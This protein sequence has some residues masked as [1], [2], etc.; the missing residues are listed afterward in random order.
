MP[1]NVHKVFNQKENNVTIADLYPQLTPAEQTASLEK[2]RRYLRVVRR[3]FDYAIEENP[4]IL[5]ELER[6]VML[7][8]TRRSKK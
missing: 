8:R 7:R 2:W 6:R 5:T 3:I 4:E 1:E